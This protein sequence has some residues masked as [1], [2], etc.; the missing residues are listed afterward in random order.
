M[1]Y[2]GNKFSIPQLFSN[3]DGKTSASGFAGML[4]IATGLVG[5]CFGIEEFWRQGKSEIMNQS[6]IVITIGAG[7]L[8]VRK[9]KDKGSISESEDDKE[10]II[11]PKEDPKIEIPKKEEEETLP[12]KPMM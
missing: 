1:K 12:P 8:G 5:F 10:E 3:G 2:D 4:C 6:I 7:L 11:I 9:A